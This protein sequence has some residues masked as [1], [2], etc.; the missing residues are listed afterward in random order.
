MGYEFDM[1][2]VRKVEE[3]PIKESEQPT[4]LGA[5]EALN[6]VD[7]TAPE[8]DKGTAETAQAEEE[9]ETV[10]A[11]SKKVHE[12]QVAAPIK[13]AKGSVKAKPAKKAKV[14]AA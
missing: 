2:S 8:A 9:G 10:V 7:R 13:K 11:P 6:T 1:P 3:V 14:A 12:D 4:I 5:D